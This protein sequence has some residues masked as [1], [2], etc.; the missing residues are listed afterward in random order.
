MHNMPGTADQPPHRVAAGQA[1]RGFGTAAA[2]AMTRVA[3]AMT[4][5]ALAL[6]GAH[7][8]EIHCDQANAASAAIARK[9]GY[10]LARVERCRPGAPGESGRLMVWVM[11]P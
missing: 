1:G 6:P 8:A 5:V 10:R 4:R 9:L 11:V 2:R 7:R 3:R